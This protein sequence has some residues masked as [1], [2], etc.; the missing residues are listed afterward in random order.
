[1]EE[2]QPAVSDVAP[3]VE[4]LPKED[5]S[6]SIDVPEEGNP[7]LQ[8]KAAS[9]SAVDDSKEVT[10]SEQPEEIQVA[11]SQS[12]KKEPRQIKDDKLIK[13]RISE[14]PA[15]IRRIMEEKFRGDFVSI[16]K[17]DEKKLL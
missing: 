16:E 4:A 17:I 10:E 15:G 2:A 5:V 13:Q 9:D 11:S 3:T 12:K 7:T 6:I 8:E 1:L 14:L